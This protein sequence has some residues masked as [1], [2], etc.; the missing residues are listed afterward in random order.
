METR[1][2]HLFA[3]TAYFLTL[4]GYVFRAFEGI[5]RWSIFIGMILVTIG[6]AILFYS[7]WQGLNKKK[8]EK[9]TSK[10]NKIGY[11]VLFMFFLGIHIYPSL[12]FTVRYYDMLAAI[13]Y[14]A[15][16]VSAY[17]PVIVSYTFLALYYVLGAYQK[18]KEEEWVD[19]LQL[20]SR[21]MLS[22]FYIY[23]I[24]KWFQA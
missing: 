3:A 8:D 5:P 2:K 19:K 15:G 21:S 11:G 23:S 4:L 6:Y 14:A 9:E 13:G 10:I 17:I 7:K 12:T 16:V 22:L 18:T 1:T 20:V 24:M